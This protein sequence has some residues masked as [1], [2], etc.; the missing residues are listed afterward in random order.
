MIDTFTSTSLSVPVPSFLEAGCAL[1]EAGVLSEAGL[2]GVAVA[3]HAALDAGI[4]FSRARQE[5]GRVLEYNTAAA[6][7]CTLRGCRELPVLARTALARGHWQ[8]AGAAVSAS[9]ARAPA[10]C[11]VGPCEA[12]GC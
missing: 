11:G 1:R 10:Q 2:T 5:R 9:V 8:P 6:T 12:V 4:V 7:A 3:A